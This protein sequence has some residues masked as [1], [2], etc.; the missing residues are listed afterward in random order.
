MTPGRLELSHKGVLNA[1]R[2]LVPIARHGCPVCANPY[3]RKLIGQRLGRLVATSD[4]QFLMNLQEH[5][6]S[7]KGCEVSVC[8]AGCVCRV[9]FCLQKLH[10]GHKRSVKTDCRTTEHSGTSA[11]AGAH[12]LSGAS[13]ECPTT[14][15]GSQEE[16][17]TLHIRVPGD[18]HVHLCGQGVVAPHEERVPLEEGV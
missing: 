12:G 13:T 5:N 18:W 7:W 6:R 10:K 2:D 14:S 11:R 8:V 17:A 4:Q 16:W 9:V 3:L 15:A 1:E